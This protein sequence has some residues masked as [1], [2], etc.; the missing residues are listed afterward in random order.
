VKCISLWDPWGTLC[1][2]GAKRNET[3]SWQPNY[4]GIVAIHVSKRW[5]PEQRRLWL[6]EPFKQW[7]ADPLVNRLWTN[8]RPP[9]GMVIGTV[10]ITGWSPTE[11]CAPTLGSDERMFG[12]YAPGRWAWHLASPRIIKPFPWRGRQGWFNVPDELIVAAA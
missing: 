8:S 7:L 4:R 3:R 2:I 5:A 10:E 9:L 1:V 11:S 6:Q 12:N